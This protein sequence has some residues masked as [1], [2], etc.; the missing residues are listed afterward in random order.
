MRYLYLSMRR[1]E[2]AA[3]NYFVEKSGF[4]GNTVTLLALLS[5][6]G[7]PSRFLADIFQLS[8]AYSCQKYVGLSFSELERSS[9]PSLAMA[10]SGQKL[11]QVQQQVDEVTHIMKKNVDYVLER[12][13]KLQDLDDR[14]EELQVG[15]NQFERQAKKIKNKMWWKNVKM[16]IILIVVLLVLGGVIGLIVYFQVK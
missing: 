7:A 5:F 3:N 9:V 15:A 10:A 11:E 2:L 8:Q 12:D 14:A 4:A 16:W 6:G 1:P 13:A